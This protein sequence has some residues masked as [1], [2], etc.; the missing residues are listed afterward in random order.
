MTTM[1]QLLIA[2]I[3]DRLNHLDTDP[4]DDSF[5]DLLIDVSATI[6]KYEDR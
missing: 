4:S 1:R 6:Q 5:N 2:G 3:F